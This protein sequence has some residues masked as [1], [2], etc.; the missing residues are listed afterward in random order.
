MAFRI[1]VIAAGA[2]PSY[3]NGGHVEISTGPVINWASYNREIPTWSN[4]SNFGWQ[5]GIVYCL[6]FLKTFDLNAGIG[7]RI[8][9]DS[10]KIIYW[11][12]DQD[13]HKTKSV[14]QIQDAKPIPG[15]I[16]EKFHLVS[17]PVGL[18]YFFR[19]IP[20]EF[21]VKL[22]PALLAYSSRIENRTVDPIDQEYFLETTNYHNKWS[23]EGELHFSIR[24]HDTK[25][26]INYFRGLTEIKNESYWL[27]P[28]ERTNSIGIFV[29][30][31]LFKR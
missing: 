18:R 12:E 20:I 1:V 3:A 24:L 16:D 2:M 22:S 9:G 26:G 19:D 5:F 17:A 15:Y 30:Q 13:G 10:K 27:D 6:P 4:R 31:S 29:S 8:A 25:I 23:L 21:G 7:Y 14:S 11:Y 28:S